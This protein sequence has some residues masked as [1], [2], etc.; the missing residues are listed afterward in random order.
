MKQAIQEG[1]ILDVLKSY[2]PV[3]SYYKLVKTVE[4]D[5]EFDARRAHKKLRRYVESHDHAI[6]LKAEIMVDHFHEQVL[7]AEQDRRPGPGDGRHAA[8]SSARSSTST[9]SAPTSLERKSP[10]QAIVAFSG[11]HEYRGSQVTEASLNGFPSEQD[12]R[13]DPGGPVPVPRLRRQVPDRLRRAAAAHDVRRQ[14]AVRRQGGAD[15]VA[16]QPGAPEEARRLRARLHERRRHDRGGVRRLLPHDDPQRGDRPEQAARPEGRPRRL[17]GLRRSQ[18]VDEFVELYLGGADR[19]QLDPILD[20]CVATYNEEL[21][22]DGQVDFKGK[23]KAFVRTYGF[24]ASILPYTN[25]E[26]EKLSI[27]LNFLIPKLPAPKEEDLSRGILETIDMDSYRVE[28]QAAMKI[29]LADEDA[30]IEPVPTSG[31]GGKP[32]PELDRLSNILKTFNDQFGNIAW[33]DADRVQRLIT[34]EIPAKVAAD[35]AYQNAKKN[36]DKQNARIEHDKALGARDERCAQGR[37]RA[38]QA[39]QRQRV[40]PAVALGQCV[41][42]HVRRERGE[43]QAWGFTPVAATSVRPGAEAESRGGSE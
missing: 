4:A 40:V 34:E 20:A 8:A 10:Y 31:G 26:W 28:K 9:R 21:D 11:E 14:A 15:A 5:P 23:A 29:A 41:F 16:A 38:L 3:D 32:E 17:R 18:Q 22:E 37:H 7:G 13:P 42:G 12:R 24:L 6:R 1:F 25:A 19:D 43:P 33:T 30:E 36:N 2:T 35:R 27:F 39:V